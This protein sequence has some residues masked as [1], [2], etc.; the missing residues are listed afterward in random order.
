MTAMVR[1]FLSNQT[2]KRFIVFVLED[3][4]KFAAHPQ[5]NL[6][7]S[8]FEM[9]LALPVYV[10]GVSC[11]IDVL[12][13][14]EKRVKS[15]F[16]QNIIYLPLPETEED[17]LKRIECNLATENAKI[18]EMFAK[19]IESH[20][21]FRQFALYH[22][23]LSKD[24]RAVFN[25]LLM[26]FSEI[27][28]IGPAFNWNTFSSVFESVLARQ[29]S[30]NSS[31]NSVA[32]TT[33]IELMVLTAMCR[34]SAKFPGNP[35]TFDAMYEELAS[36]KVRAQ[37]LDC[38]VWTKS[39]IQVAFDRLLSCRLL[40]PASSVANSSSMNRSYLTVRLG[41]PQFLVVEAVQN[42][43]YDSKEIAALAAER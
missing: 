40:I 4:E 3:L 37:K 12:E 41:L 26:V 31:L 36:C 8:L 19:F 9:T 22:F 6:L 2:E 15:R 7:Y 35:V 34:L 10:I 14:L 39:M 42:H 18:D 5:Q 33:L 24:V 30:G 28:S 17:Y 29:M 16:S 21:G 43:P 13:L 32:E 1:T 11:R 27:R 38:F 20:E 23:S 25:M